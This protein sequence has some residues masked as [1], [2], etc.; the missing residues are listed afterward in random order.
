[1]VT[2]KDYFTLLEIYT[3]SQHR[4]LPDGRRP[5]WIDEDLNPRNGEWIARTLLE[6]RGSAIPE[7]GKDY[8]HSTFCDLIITG[9]VGL[10]PRADNVIELDPLAPDSW[11]YFCLDQVRY[12]GHRVTIL[13]D[14][15]GKHYGKGKG[16]RLIVDGKERSVALSLERLTASYR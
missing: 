1:V 10:R 13:W 9:L 16:L 4:L 5:P 15:T 6:R 8:N 7:R 12:H 14:K 2:K 11:D 3:R